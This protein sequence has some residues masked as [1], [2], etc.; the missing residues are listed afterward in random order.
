MPL[1]F[2]NE[3]SCGSECDPGRADSAMTELAR[4]VLA[5]AGAD[6]KGT[7][8]VTEEPI[9]NL[10]IA[11]G[12]SIG[13]WSGKPSS[14]DLW[15]RLL[16]MQSKWPHRAVFPEGEG[17]YEVDYSHREES[18]VGLGAA[19]LMDGIGV[20]LPVE[21]W[22]D[23]P[24]L[25]LRRAEMVTGDDGQPGIEVS[26]VEIR[27]ASCPL[28]VDSHLSWI[29]DCVAAVR[30]GGLGA[31]RQGSHLWEERTTLFPHLEFLPQVEQNLSGL[32]A[33]W[34]ASVGRTLTVLDAAAADWDLNTD[35][36]C[37]PC[38]VRIRPEYEVRRRL[39][40]F[41]DLDGSE[42]LFDWHAD[43]AP[44]PGRIHF[45]LVHEKATLR[46]AYVGRKLGV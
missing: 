28:H 27:H 35:P 2:L 18:A 36:I 23:V 12:H 6:R 31:V 10:Q 14:R 33:A 13:K 26:D 20:S 39:C 37:P 16:Q 1:L 15:V 5:V 9:K 11:N 21:T 3:K 4:A 34:V 24:R 44:R 43:F 40:W 22:W 7:V 45:R 17:F 41:T 25:A 42:Q 38:E 19:H 8:L 32:P 30:K 46:I 29:K